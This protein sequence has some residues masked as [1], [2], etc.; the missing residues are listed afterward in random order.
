MSSL[1][2]VVKRFLPKTAL[3]IMS[4]LSLILPSFASDLS[5]QDAEILPC[6]VPAAQPPLKRYEPGK[7]LAKGKFLVA[8]RN[9]MD[10]RFAETV[11]LLIDYSTEGAVGLII[12]RPTEMKLSAALSDIK[13]LKQREDVVYFGGPV[14]LSQM[15]MLIR[16]AAQPE[17]SSRV[18]DDIYAS[19]SLTLLKRMLDN[20]KTGKRF[21]VYAGYAGWAPFQL[22]GE[23]ARGDWHVTWADAETIFERKPSEIWPELIRRGTAQWVKA[24]P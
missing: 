21:H 5:G 3:I 12:N 10:P 7:A 20:E 1:P 13:E 23:V 14:G 8:G 19:S 16:S 4:A 24:G 2:H 17:G 11:I 22:D 15:F 9:M 18:L 6:S